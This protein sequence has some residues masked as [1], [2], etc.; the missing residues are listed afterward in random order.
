MKHIE[1]T[2]DEKPGHAHLLR[3]ARELADDLATDAALREQ[4]GKAPYDEVARLREAGLLALLV[5]AEH[6][7]G[8]VDWRTA[9]EVVRTISAAD[10]AIGQLLGFLNGAHPPF[11]LPS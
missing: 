3:I 1:E 5:P 9:Y 2:A 8:R 6:G 7:G 10:G 11:T 4:G